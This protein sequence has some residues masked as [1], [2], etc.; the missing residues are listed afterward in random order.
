MRS[1][2][3]N[4]LPDAESPHWRREMICCGCDQVL[5]LV[6]LQDVVGECYNSKAIDAAQVEHFRGQ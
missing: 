2:V 5:V 1:H 3:E 4:K 6:A